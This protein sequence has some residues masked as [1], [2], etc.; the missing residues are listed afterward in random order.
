[1][2]IIPKILEMLKEIVNLESWRQLSILKE[3]VNLD[4][5]W[6]QLSIPKI[7]E[8]LKTIVNLNLEEK[9]ISKILGM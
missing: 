9:E 4:E 7:L 6:R 2:K 3:I 5:S 8:I 1:M